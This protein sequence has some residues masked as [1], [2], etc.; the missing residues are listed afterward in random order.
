MLLEGKVTKIERF[1]YEAFLRLIN[2]NIDGVS[3]LSVQGNEESL[4]LPIKKT[5]R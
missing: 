3:L 5:I 2:T 1:P 4:R